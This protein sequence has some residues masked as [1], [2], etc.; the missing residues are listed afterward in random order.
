MKLLGGRKFTI[1]VILLIT[2]FILFMMHLIDA[3][4]W[5][6][7]VTAIFGLYVAGNVGEHF[8]QG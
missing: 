8:T 2:N 7:L 3:E 1:M 6:W 5:K 4:M